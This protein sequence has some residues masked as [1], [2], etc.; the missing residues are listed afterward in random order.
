MESR[1]RMAGGDFHFN[2]EPSS[3]RGRLLNG[4]IRSGI[5]IGFCFVLFRNVFIKDSHQKPGVGQGNQSEAK[6]DPNENTVDKGIA[7]EESQEYCSDGDN[8]HNQCLGQM[9]DG[10]QEGVE[11]GIF[12]AVVKL[13]K[14]R[15]QVHENHDCQ[16]A[17]HRNAYSQNTGS[18][19]AFHGAQN[20]EIHVEDKSEDQ[21]NEP[22]NGGLT[23]ILLKSLEIS[24][25]DIGFLVAHHFQRHIIQGCPCSANGYNG[26][27]GDQ[28][29]HV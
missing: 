1:F 26:D 6:H 29:D 12:D 16:R 25:D 2:Q 5:R 24:P 17:D 28:E 3:S 4:I 9:P 7:V 10:H 13:G 18:G 20:T 23:E 11:E 22:H 27:A 14:Q 8:G 15:K 19:S 21:D